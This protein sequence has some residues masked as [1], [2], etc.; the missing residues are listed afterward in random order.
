MKPYI[1]TKTLGV[2][3]GLLTVFLGLGFGILSWIGMGL[4][5]TLH[6]EHDMSNMIPMILL[7][8]SLVLG[9]ITV[10]GV[11]KLN[12][13]IWSTIFVSVY[14]ILGV[15]M[16]GFFLISFGSL[17]IRYEIFILCVG[18]IYM[19]LGYSALRKK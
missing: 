4:S 14:I 16:I 8:V 13:K 19:G 7:P 15:T 10:F 6:S 9:G 1:F 12:N 3:A 18:I 17:G 11:F 5:E 2:I